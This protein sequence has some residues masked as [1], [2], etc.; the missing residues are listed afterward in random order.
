MAGQTGDPTLVP[1]FPEEWKPYFGPGRGG[2]QKTGDV[3]ADPSCAN[4][5]APG[6]P[7]GGSGGGSGGAGGGGSNT[8]PGGVPCRVPGGIVGRGI[9]G[10][11]LGMKRRTARDDL[12]APA[13]ESVRYV[14]WCFEG[15]GK[16]VAAF[17][18]RNDRAK[19]QLVWTN[20][21][22]FDVRSVRT[23]SAARTARKR[24]KGEKRL[25][26]GVLVI[27]ERK[28]QLLVGLARSRVTY[29]AVAP[30]KMSRRGVL[31]LL[32]NAP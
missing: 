13:T 19:A 23:G 1:G 21:Q 11:T 22:P 20:A 26:R 24:L 2:V 14:T 4:K 8:S 3:P 9:G 6:S 29:L 17:T 28:R 15:G 25:A 18:G 32:R 30:P 16:L 31:K 12:G 10:V 27:R 7:S 5:P